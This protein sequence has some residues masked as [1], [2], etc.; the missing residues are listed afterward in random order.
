MVAAHHMGHRR[1]RIILVQTGVGGGNGEVANGSGV[2]RVAK[3]KDAADCLICYQ[4]DLIRVLLADKERLLH[5]SIRLAIED[6]ERLLLVGQLTNESDLQTICSKLK[7]DILLLDTNL[8]NNLL[9]YLNLIKSHC[10]KLKILLLCS[11]PDDMEAKLLNHE[12]VD[13][14]LLKS[15]SPETL[16]NALHTIVQGNPWFSS[17]LLKIMRQNNQQESN[18]LLT[19]REIELL[20]LIVAEKKDKEIAQVLNV[21]TRTIRYYLQNI[22]NKLGINTRA[23]AIYQATKRNLI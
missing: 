12:D 22:Y 14:G 9:H 2:Q 5:D 3:I 6:D 8:S 19:N 13:G 4:F 7:P 23:A 20:R 11:N 21:S 10:P 16:L 17:S 18:A 15:E 1:Q